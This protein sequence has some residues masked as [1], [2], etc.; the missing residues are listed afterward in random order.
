MVEGHDARRLLPGPAHVRQ[1]RG[2]GGHAAACSAAR[3]WARGAAKRIDVV[4]EDVDFIDQAARPARRRRRSGV[5]QRALNLL[6]AVD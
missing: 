5:V 3:S 4:D 6:R 2:R 1:A